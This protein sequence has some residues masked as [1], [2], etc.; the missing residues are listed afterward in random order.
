MFDIDLHH[1]SSVTEAI[2][3]L[4]RELFF[5]YQKKVS[6]CTIIFG[7]GEGVLRAAVLQELKKHPQVRSVSED[8]SG[9]SCVVTL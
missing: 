4:N 2:E 3:Q 9:G 1:S 8:E 5:A 6:Q 7:I